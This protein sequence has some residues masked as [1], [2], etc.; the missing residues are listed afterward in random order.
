MKDLETLR[1]ELTA[2]VKGAAQLDELE[3]IRVL[4]LGKKAGSRS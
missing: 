3:Q 2:A 4:A 1:S